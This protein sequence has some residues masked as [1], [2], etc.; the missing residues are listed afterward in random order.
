LRYNHLSHVSALVSR[1]SH[2]ICLC[3]MSY[4]VACLVPWKTLYA[5]PESR[6][7]TVPCQ[8]MPMP[9]ALCLKPKKTLYASPESR[10]N[11]VPCQRS[12][13]VSVQSVCFPSL[14][15]FKASQ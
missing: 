4:V 2:T 14:V 10:A 7:N 9:Y 15:C 11:T 12:C 13:K 5:S 8:L 1:V 3:L 6:A